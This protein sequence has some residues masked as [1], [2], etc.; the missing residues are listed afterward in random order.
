MVRFCANR[1]DRASEWTGGSVRRDAIWQ[2][3]CPCSIARRS[4]AHTSSASRRITNARETAAKLGI[5]LRNARQF[6]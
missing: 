2:A 1:R 6:V 5:M 3:S 4:G